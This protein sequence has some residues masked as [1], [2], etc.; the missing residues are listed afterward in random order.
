MMLGVSWFRDAYTPRVTPGRVSWD[1][2]AARL[3]LHKPLERRA[4]VCP[5]K[6]ATRRAWSPGAC[7]ACGAERVLDKRTAGAWSPWTFRDDKRSDLSAVLGCALVVDYDGGASLETVRQTWAGFEHVA[8]TSWS[9][10]DPDSACVRV[11]LPLA[12]PV[13]ASLY[14]RLFA[15]SLD[16]A[17]EQDPTVTDPGRLWFLPFTHGAPVASWHHRGPWL[18]VD[19]SA[20]PPHPSERPAARP[21]RPR[22]FERSD[23]YRV[24]VGARRALG[25]QLGGELGS[26]GPAEVVR[27]VPCPGC[28]QRTVWWPVQPRGWP[29]AA[30]DHR[31]S[32]GWVGF[33]DELA[34]EGA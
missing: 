7:G 3:T 19:A 4:W 5:A 8:H 22:V 25:V 27:H 26:S 34:G 11:V 1:A 28:G 30:C 24:D 18:D 12:E 15:W 31:R 10:L 6:C 2:L 16:R 17:P 29:G 21:Q 33:L 9:H 23:L 32:C 13:R 14:R 20:L